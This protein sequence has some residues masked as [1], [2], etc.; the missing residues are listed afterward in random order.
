MTKILMCIV[1]VICFVVYMS[2]HDTYIK[3]CMDAGGEP[4]LTIDK[5]VCLHPSAV[6][7]LD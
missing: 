4:I 6:L 1:F 7:E 5:A 3:K 2:Y